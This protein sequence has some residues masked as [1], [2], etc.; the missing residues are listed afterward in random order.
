MPQAVSG[1]TRIV[2]PIAIFHYTTASPDFD[3]FVLERRGFAFHYREYLDWMCDL[4]REQ[5]R[6]F[7]IEWLD[8]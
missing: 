2:K 5:G 6:H 4:A 1:V 8:A 7:Y 3:R